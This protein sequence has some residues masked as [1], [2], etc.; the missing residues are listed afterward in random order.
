M[1][2]YYSKIRELE[3]KLEY[4]QK[5]Y[6]KLRKRRKILNVQKETGMWTDEVIQEL[7]LIRIAMDSVFVNMKHI[8]EQLEYL[9][10]EYRK[11]NKENA[12][13]F[14]NPMDEKDIIMIIHKD[15]SIRGITL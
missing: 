10:E 12:R 13:E 9:R 8:S 11:Y 7:E 2:N 14:Y 3:K 6:D 5:V 4:S 15:G 1:E